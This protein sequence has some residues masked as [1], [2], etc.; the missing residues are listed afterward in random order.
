MESMA[1]SKTTIID[2]E[3]VQEQNIVV[4][5]S[6]GLFVIPE[7]DYKWKKYGQKYIRSMQKNSYF[8]CVNKNCKTRK[9]VELPPNEPNNIDIA[10]EGDH[11]YRALVGRSENEEARIAANQ[12]DLATQM[13]G[14]ART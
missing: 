12:Y 14:Y 5:F 9:K 10:Y 8:R 1:S 13:F 3:Q 11:N 6:N 4:A 7:D 2:E